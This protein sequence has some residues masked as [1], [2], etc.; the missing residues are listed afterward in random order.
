MDSKRDP[1]KDP[2]PGDVTMFSG[3][4]ITFVYRV[5]RLEERLVYYEWIANG[6]TLE[7]ETY[8]QYW[9]GSSENDEVLYVAS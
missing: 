1:R 8:I 7:H 3:G 5:T 6:E 4:G 2:R 9:I